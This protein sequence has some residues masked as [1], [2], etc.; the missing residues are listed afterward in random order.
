MSEYTPK[1]SNPENPNRKRT[2]KIIY[3]IAL[4]MAAALL[5]AAIITICV[6]FF[7]GREYS[8]DYKNNTNSTVSTVLPANPIDFNKLQEQYPDACAWIRLPGIE[9]ID[10]PIFQSAVEVDD[11]FY[12]DHNRD[13]K[14]DRYGEII[15]K[16]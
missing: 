8:D 2:N 3:Y 13:G 14:S 12:L 4:A 10:L 16:S 15:F 6:S 1:H 11:N 7:G 5:L 9:Q